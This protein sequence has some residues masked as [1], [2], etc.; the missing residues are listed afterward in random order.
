MHNYETDTGGVLVKSTSRSLSHL[1]VL[2]K[3]TSRS[4]SH[5]QHIE[6]S[7]ESKCIQAHHHTQPRARRLENPLRAY[8]CNRQTG[9]RACARCPHCNRTSATC[10]PVPCFESTGLARLPPRHHQGLIQTSKMTRRKPF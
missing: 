8:H 7:S 9:T 10:L 2:E 1:Q 6:Q 5:L 4:L 3:S